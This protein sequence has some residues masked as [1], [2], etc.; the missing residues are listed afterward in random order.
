M[1]DTPPDR[2]CANPNSPYYN[3]ALLERGIGIR[4]N[5]VEKTN[6]DEYCVSEGWV[7][8]TA[9]AA[10]DRAGNPMTIK[11]KGKVEPYFRQAE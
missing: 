11:L 8:V 1:T 6:V 2:L 4:F 5:G 7:R 9:G 10:K 3:E